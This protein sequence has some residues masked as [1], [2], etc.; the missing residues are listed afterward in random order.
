MDLNAN[1]TVNADKVADH[2]ADLDADRKAK[3]KQDLKEFYAEEDAYELE[4]HQNIV[5]HDK[6]R[7][8]E[9]EK[10]AAKANIKQ[11]DKNLQQAQKDAAIAAGYTS[12]A[13]TSLMNALMGNPDAEFTSQEKQV[14]R[15]MERAE[16]ASRD[17]Q[18]AMKIGKVGGNTA[19]DEKTPGAL[20]TKRGVG[21]ALKELQER[22]AA[23]KAAKEAE[24]KALKQQEDMVTALKNIE[25]GING[26]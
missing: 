6:K 26:G 18:E 5:A 3:Q 22:K 21:K 16:G 25:R 13:R 14:N 8:D 2:Q 1:E 11:A 20:S 7:A 4:K 24:N 10:D 9:K 12:D 17:K 19:L 15:L 23:E